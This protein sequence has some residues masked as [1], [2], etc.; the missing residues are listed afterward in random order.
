[1]IKHLLIV[2]VGLIGGSFAL[3]L[4]R[5]GLVERVTGIGRSRANLETALQLGVIDA[6]GRNLASAAADADLIMLAVPVGAMPAVFAELAPVLPPNCIVTDAGSTKQDV[7][8]AARA[9]LGERVAQFVPGHPIAGAET[10]GAAAAR[11]GLYAD[12][13]LILTPLPENRAADVRLVESLWGACGARLA[14]MEA[15]LHDQVFAAVSHLPHLL[16]FAL[17]DELASRPH[18]E[19]YFRYAGAGLRDATRIAGSHPEMWRDITLANREPL[20]DELDAMVEKLKSV[21]E[22]VAT[23]DGTALEEVFARARQ[24]RESWLQGKFNE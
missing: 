11:I 19:I 7:I 6:I 15:L 20:L 4:K 21:R 5:Q 12:K 23:R 1:M 18:A 8:A 13:P 9:G 3:D 24:A 10:N 14:R 22:L 2:G 17:M 16:A